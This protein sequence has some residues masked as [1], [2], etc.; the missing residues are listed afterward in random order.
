LARGA[1]DVI[2]AFSFTL[3]INVAEKEDSVLKYD[4]HRCKFLTRHAPQLNM[5]MDF[6]QIIRVS[7]DSQGTKFRVMPHQAIK[8]V[9]DFLSYHLESPMSM[10]LT[11]IQSVISS[12]I[13]A[14]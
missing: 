3:K 13:L 7:Y 14:M 9:W 12:T 1:R 6:I 2:C 10:E 4:G 11:L 8:R 5:E